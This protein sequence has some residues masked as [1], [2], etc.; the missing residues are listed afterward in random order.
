[1]ETDWGNRTVVV[2][3]AAVRIGR[4]IALAFGERGARV[5]VHYN[6]S[7]EQALGVVRRI[8]EMGGAAIAVEA[9]LSDTRAAVGIIEC[10]VDAFGQVDIL[11]NSASVFRRGTIYDTSEQDW[12][13]HFAINL[14]APFFMSQALAHQVGGRPG[15]QI[16]NVTD[17]RAARPGKAY[18]AYV[19]TKAALEAM[20]RSL[21]LALGPNVRV[22][23]VA[24]GAILPVSG[25]QTDYFERL[26]R[27]LP[28]RRTGSPQEIVKAIMYLVEAEFVTGETITVDG[29]EHL[30]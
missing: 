5:V 29:G 7:A 18:A 25:D 30:L 1:M 22:N 21:A 28:V 6:S 12:D 15:C 3:G 10:A 20:T 4:A 8:R 27:R 19:L 9:D 11:V 24:P 16:I 13:E 2:T 14:K 17:W 26:A 23:A